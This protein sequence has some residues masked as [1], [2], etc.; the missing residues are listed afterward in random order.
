MAGEKPVVFICTGYLVKLILYIVAVYCLPFVAFLHFTHSVVN[1]AKPPSSVYLLCGWVPRFVVALLAI[2]I[3][4]GQIYVIATVLSM[5]TLA[6]V[7]AVCGPAAYGRQI[8][9][10]KI[11]EK[12]PIALPGTPELI[13]WNA[14]VSNI[15]AMVKG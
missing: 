12:I 14:F 1:V 7:L 5:T 4:C 6:L 2:A 3:P 10:D 9:P 15:L 11:P 8:I 13:A